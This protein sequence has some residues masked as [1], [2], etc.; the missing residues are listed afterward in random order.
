MFNRIITS[1]VLHDISMNRKQTTFV[2]SLFEGVFH[3]QV[4]RIADGQPPLPEKQAFL[5][6]SVRRN[7]RLLLVVVILNSHA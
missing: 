5:P 4:K 1:P 7:D 6:F 2:E 3:G